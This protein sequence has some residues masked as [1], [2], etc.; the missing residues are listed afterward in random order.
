MVVKLNGDE[1]WRGHTHWGESEPNF[2]EMVSLQLN[3]NTNI[4]IEMW[5]NDPGPGDDLMSEWIGSVDSLSQLSHLQ[6]HDWG[7]GNQNYV[8]IITEWRPLS[9]YNN[10][11]NDGHYG[12]GNYNNGHNYPINNLPNNNYPNN[13]NYNHNNP[14][15]NHN[16]G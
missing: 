12:N 6:G 5:D 15:N 16:F 3:R 14:N 7:N 1:V 10:N 9:N 4:E 11:Y 13:N 8:S 2:D